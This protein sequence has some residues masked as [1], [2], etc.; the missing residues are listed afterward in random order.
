MGN[1]PLRFV[2]MIKATEQLK[3]VPRVGWIVK[4][5]VKNPESVADHSFA[6]ALISMLAGDMLGLN[7]LHMVRLALLHDLSESLTGDIQPGDLPT[8]KKHRLERRAFRALTKDLPLDIRLLYREIFDDFLQ[9]KSQEAK[10]VSQ[11]D[12][13]EM[14]LQAESYEK[15]GYRRLEEFYRTAEAKVK[16]KRLATL[17][18]GLLF[19]DR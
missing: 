11:I 7:T 12:K 17:M 9:Q 15:D 4:V 18:K 6:V 14:A 1:D 8:K 13:L 19:L 5:G 2:E 3:K 10:L 16:D